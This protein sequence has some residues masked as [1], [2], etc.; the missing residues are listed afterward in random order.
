MNACEITNKRRKFSKLHGNFWKNSQNKPSINFSGKN[1]FSIEKAHFWNVSKTSMNAVVMLYLLLNSACIFK[2]IWASDAH[3]VGP[4]KR[5]LET[6]VLL[7][8]WVKWECAIVGF[9]LVFHFIFEISWHLPQMILYTF[10]SQNQWQL[11]D[12]FF[13]FD[14]KNQG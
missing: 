2:N 3:P 1:V 6:L 7:E 9:C 14:S 8:L 12:T 4:L 13:R 5:I 11:V 10:K